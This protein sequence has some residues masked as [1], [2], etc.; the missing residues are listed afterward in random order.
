MGKGDPEY[1]TGVSGIELF[2]LIMKEAYGKDV[3]ISSVER[4]IRTPEY[5]MGWAIAYYQWYTDRTYR[6]IF[7]ALSYSTL[8][9]MYPTLHESD[10]TKFVDECDKL[11]KAYYTETNLKRIRKMRGMTQ[12]GLSYLS[13][14]GLRSI[15]LY[16]QRVKD[17]NKASIDAVYRLAKVLHTSMESLMEK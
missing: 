5:W 16:E 9:F 10:I 4:Y 1:I 7:Q 15:Q 17:I 8:L 3:D 11:V 6:E 2:A 13:G 12:S 14:V